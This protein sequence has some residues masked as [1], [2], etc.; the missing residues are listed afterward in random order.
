MATAAGLTPLRYL[1]QGGKS[2]PAATL[3]VD[4]WDPT[5]GVGDVA[6][7]TPQF[8]IDAAGKSAGF[9]VF[10]L[11]GA[12]RINKNLKVSAGVNSQKIETDQ[13]ATAMHEMTATA[14][15]ALK[16]TTMELGGSDAFKIGRA[17]V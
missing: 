14:G 1:A 6:S 17:H 11:N 8:T 7:F 5:A 3:P 15:K 2:L 13:V 4:N 9:G 12:Y 16:K 10:S